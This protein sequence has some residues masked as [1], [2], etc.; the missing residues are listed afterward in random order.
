M[1]RETKLG[2]SIVGGMV[3]VLGFL[4]YGLFALLTQGIPAVSRIATNQRFGD[5]GTAN[6]NLYDAGPFVRDYAVSAVLE[7]PPVPPEHD[8][9]SVQLGFMQNS[10]NFQAGLIR[11]PEHKFRLESFVSYTTGNGD[12]RMIYIDP[13]ADGPHTLELRVRD[14]TVTFYADDRLRFTDAGSRSIPPNSNPWLFLGTS[15]TFIGNSAFGTISDIRVRR[16][17][18][19]SMRPEVPRC[20]ISNGGIHIMPY[21]DGWILSGTTMRSVPIRYAG[22]RGVFVR[23][24]ALAAQRT[25]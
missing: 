19:T 14:T 1:N 18:D 22:C 6:A 15:A 11:T 23:H 16:D 2:L 4:A 12:Q 25:R 8:S 7:L 20:N 5:N 24:R 17:G 10:G 3:L 9:P 13:L 21:G